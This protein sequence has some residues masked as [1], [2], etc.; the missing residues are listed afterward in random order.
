LVVA[1]ALDAFS[2]SAIVIDDGVDVALD[3][4]APTGDLLLDVGMIDRGELPH[5][6]SFADAM[7]QCTNQS[8]GPTVPISGG[9]L[10]S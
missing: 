8:A 1:T 6:R 10:A 7:C 3:V 5:R 9:V 2:D 4:N